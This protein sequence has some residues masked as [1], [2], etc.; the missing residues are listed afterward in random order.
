MTEFHT[1]NLLFYPDVWD[2]EDPT[3]YKPG[4]YHPIVLGD[5]LYSPF[6][7]SSYRIFQKLG[8]GSFSTVWLAENTSSQPKYVAVKV[9]TADGMSSGEADDLRSISSPYI[10]PVVDSFS[11]EGPNG[12]HHVLVIEV[13][14]P[15]FEFLKLPHNLGT[16][17]RII[18]ELVKAVEDVHAA[19]LVHGDL[20][21]GNAG[22]TLPQLQSLNIFAVAL[23]S[24]DPV[25]IP[26]LFSNTPKRTDSLPAYLTR[27]CDVK[28]LLKKSTKG[29]EYE[30]RAK[31]F[32]FGSV[33]RQGDD[34]KD[35]MCTRLSRAPEIVCELE[36][37]E[38]S[39]PLLR[40]ASDIWA[41]GTVIFEIMT[42]F[43]VFSSLYSPEFMR[44]SEDEWWRERWDYLRRNCFD[45]ADCDTLVTLLKK[46]LV[47]EPSD[48]PS[49][50]TIAQDDWFYEIRT[51]HSNAPP[52]P[53]PPVQDTQ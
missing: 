43:P 7:T 25:L 3:R 41:L 11:L 39:N 2:E 46:I 52:R 15:V 6:G 38:D 10:V 21:V 42:E 5:I 28:N 24:N 47:I 9:T 1:R 26:I 34:S 16:R 4:G 40:P 29:G 19:G 51:A 12:L 31:L 14:V 33:R 20:H 17:R 35:F 18:W 48:R 44:L 53:L 8:S 36:A 30:S 27:R 45:D 50:A 32:D 22:V 13:L 37:D 49:A 23:H